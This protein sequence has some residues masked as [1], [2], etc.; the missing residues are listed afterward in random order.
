MADGT[1]QGP[2]RQPEEGITNSLVLYLAPNVTTT[3]RERTM[4]S[5]RRM[6][7]SIRTEGRTARSELQKN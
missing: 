4:A 6:H 7:Q 2:I 1:V 5:V 3:P